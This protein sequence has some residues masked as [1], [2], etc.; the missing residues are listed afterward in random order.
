MP[1]FRFDNAACT[2]YS[3]N[4]IRRTGTGARAYVKT[5]ANA[6][7]HTQTSVHTNLCPATHISHVRNKKTTLPIIKI[8][9][10]TFAAISRLVVTHSEFSGFDAAVCDWRQ[11]Q[12]TAG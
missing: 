4:N 3:F 11:F 7:T 6:R 12:Q 1:T 8:V 5:C 2:D 10:P 9:S